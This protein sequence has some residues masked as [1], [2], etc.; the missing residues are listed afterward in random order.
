MSR[1]AVVGPQN[2]P[3]PTVLATQD[4]AKGFNRKSMGTEMKLHHGNT[5]SR[6]VEHSLVTVLFTLP[7]YVPVFHAYTTADDE[8]FSDH[9]ETCPDSPEES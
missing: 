2:T 1:G 6:V 9:V 7:P 3:W 5:L 4:C 8:L